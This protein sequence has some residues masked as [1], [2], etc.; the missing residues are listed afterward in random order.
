MTNT[1]N[2]KSVKDF[3]YVDG[4]KLHSFYSQLFEGV[5]ETITKSKIDSKIDK[6]LQKG[7]PVRGELSE[8]EIGLVVQ[9]TESSVL[10]DHMFEQLEKRLNLAIVDVSS[11]NKEN[12]RDALKNPFLVKIQGNA[13]FIDFERLNDILTNFN[14]LGKGLA[15]MTAINELGDLTPEDAQKLVGNMKNSPEKQNLQ[16]FVNQYKDIDK[17]AKERNL[18]RDP[19]QN[20]YLNLVSNTFYLDSYEVIIAPQGNG[21]VNY[22]GVINKKWLRIDPN[23]LRQLFCGYSTFEFTMVG[24]VTFLPPENEAKLVEED[25]KNINDGVAIKEKAL[26]SAESNKEQKKP[27]TTRD[28][29]SDM[30]KAL[31]AFKRVFIERSDATEVIIQPLAIYKESIINLE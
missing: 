16:L 25:G 29:F 26:E 4:E 1:N 12:F 30:Q 11:I 10:Y 15:Y 2:T 24:Q 17:L 5:T 6:G 3:I 13:E 18:Y 28:S 31:R 7:Q 21:E 8:E 20:D 27:S 23:L 9:S 19:K 14:K 22:R